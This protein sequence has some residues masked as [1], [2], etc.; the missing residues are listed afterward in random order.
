MSEPDL[1][2]A[3]H[4]HA[5]APLRGVLHALEAIREPPTP[6]LLRELSKNVRSALDQLVAPDPLRSRME[7]VLLAIR[8]STE[9]KK[10]IGIN[11][12]PTTRVIVKDLELYNWAME[13]VHH[14]IHI[15]NANGQS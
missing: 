5:L 11:E 2:Q 3:P 8:T 14:L 7:F 10:V 13:Q 1:G 15:P 12:V 6:E 4:F 9:V